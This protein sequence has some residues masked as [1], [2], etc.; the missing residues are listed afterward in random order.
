MLEELVH[1]KSGEWTFSMCQSHPMLS[2]IMSHPTS[3]QPLISIVFH[4]GTGHTAELAKAVAAGVHSAGAKVE[5]HRISEEDFKGGRWLNEEV[6][7]RLDESDAIIFGSPTYM[8][9][10]SAQLKSFMDAT[11]PRY[12]QRKWVDKIGAAFT[13]S[14]LPSGDK[15][16]MLI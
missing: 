6:L 11:S 14:G 5:V 4:S 16:N 8:G 10:V 12:L 2:H 9:G 3:E 13:V 1:P 15:L 7:A